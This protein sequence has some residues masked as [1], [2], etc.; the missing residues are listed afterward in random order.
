[1]ERILWR[2]ERK[3]RNY[4]GKPSCL[5]SEIFLKKTRSEDQEDCKPKNNPPDF[6]PENSLII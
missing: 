2:W 4:C 1:M 6:P 5:N 3:Q